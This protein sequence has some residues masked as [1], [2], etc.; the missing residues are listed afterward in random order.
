M[1][2]SWLVMG[3]AVALGLALWMPEGGAQPNTLKQI[4]RGV[5]F[6]EGDIKVGHC[7]N[8]LIEMKDYLVVVDANFPSGARLVL[9]AAKR[10]S[11]KPVKYVFDTHH[12]GD[13]LYGNPVFTRMGAITIGHEGV[14][15]ELKRVEPKRWRQAMK[16]RADVADLKLDRPEPPARTFGEK[17]FVISDGARRIELH[18]FGWAH[19]RGDGFLYLPNEKVLCTGDAIVNGPYNYTGDGNVGN[20][21]KVI[22]A[23][24]RL[25]VERVLPGH[26]GAGGKEL[27]EKQLEFFLE[28]QKAVRQAVKEGKKLEDVVSLKEGRAVATVVKLPGSVS[29]WVGDFLPAQVQDTYEEITQGRPHGEILNGK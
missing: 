21:P 7:N 11:S 6:R 24:Q 20:W 2:R 3:F 5:W 14:V 26:G 13:H 27:M 17:P 23:A 19:T 1:K 4:V 22:R 28:L 15:E 10:V 29:H 16:E 8:I 18:F 12:H 9:E 25:E